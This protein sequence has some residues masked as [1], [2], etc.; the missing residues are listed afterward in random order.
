[1]RDKLSAFAGLAILSAAALIGGRA[2]AQV[3][4]RPAAATPISA[5]GNAPLSA[6]AV[7]VG[8]ASAAATPPTSDMLYASMLAAM[9]RHQSIAARIRYRVAEYGQQFVGAGIYSQQAM[10]AGQG[11]GE[12]LLR[13]ELKMQIAEQVCSLLQVSDGNSFWTNC[14]L[15]NHVP[16]TRVDLARVRRGIARQPKQTVTPQNAWMAL[17]GLPKLLRNLRGNFDFGP[18]E[19]GNLERLPVWIVRGQ[20]RPAP[21]SVMLPGQKDKILAGQPADLT[22]LPANAPDSVVM[23]I[24]REDLFPYRVEYR[25]RLAKPKRLPFSKTEFA[26]TVLLAME[27]YEVQFDTPLEPRQFIYSPGDLAVIDQTDI[28]LQSLGLKDDPAPNVTAPRSPQQRLTADR[29]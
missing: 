8:S 4:T 16:L 23:L 28:F 2:E 25:R 12:L 26:D 20:W 15:P 9:E 21:L 27:W 14:D 19:E 29:A 24:G 11:R 13:L 3:G 18:V 22:N 10:P 1:M 7:T 6:P 17:G 5:A